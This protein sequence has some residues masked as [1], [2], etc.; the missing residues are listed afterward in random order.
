MFNVL[1]SGRRERG[2]EN[3]MVRPAVLFLLSCSAACVAGVFRKP[4][5]RMRTF[6]RQHTTRDG[7]EEDDDVLG[8]VAASPAA[9]SEGGV[10]SLVTKQLSLVPKGLSLV[11]NG[12]SLGTKQLVAHHAIV[13]KVIVL[14]GPVENFIRRFLGG[15]TQRDKVWAEYTKAR[16]LIISSSKLQGTALARVL[17]DLRIEHCRKYPAWREIFIL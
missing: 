4:P 3:P 8:P 2:K 11:T 10:L 1:V 6:H 15:R 16:D 12:L 7:S 9:G 14:K 13:W 17:E 5:A